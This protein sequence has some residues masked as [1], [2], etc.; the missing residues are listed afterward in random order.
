VAGAAVAEAFDF[1]KAIEDR[2][3][4]TAGVS[5]DFTISGTVVM[6]AEAAASKD[7]GV[8]SAMLIEIGPTVKIVARGSVDVRNPNPEGTISLDV[9]ALANPAKGGN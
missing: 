9:P 2:L 8:L 1:T 4:F 7:V 3:L 5:D 6:T